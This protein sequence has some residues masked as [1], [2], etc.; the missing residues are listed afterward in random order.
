MPLQWC[1]L[2]HYSPVA[3]HYSA[4][5]CLYSAVARLYSAVG[6]GA[7]L[8]RNIW[9]LWGSSGSALKSLESH[10]FVFY[11]VQMLLVLHPA[12]TIVERTNLSICLRAP[13][14]VR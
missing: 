8:G 11:C 1:S 2:C 13:S 7:P 12:R 10:L 5:A 3:C 6:G 4:V 14:T 9:Y